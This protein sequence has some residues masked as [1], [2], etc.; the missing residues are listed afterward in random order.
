[1]T[2]GGESGIGVPEPV[3][4]HLRKRFDI[5][6]VLGRGGSAIVLRA[7]HRELDRPVA[8]KL[9]A[10]GSGGDDLVL[11]RAEF[12]GRSQSSLSHPNLVEVYETERLGEHFL[13]VSELVEGGTLLAWMQE[14]HPLPFKAVIERML[15]ITRGLEAIHAAG[16][17]HRDLKAVNI[18]LDHDRRAR[19]TDF[20]LASG[21][22]RRRK[23]LAGMILGTFEYMAPEQVQGQ[24]GDHRADLY[25]LGVLGYELAAGVLPFSGSNPQE[26]LQKIMKDPPRPLAQV[27]GDTPTWYSQ[28]IEGQL[29]AKKPEDRP[30]N[31]TEVLRLLER[32]GSGEV[33]KITQPIPASMGS[34]PR[35]VLTQQVS[36]KVKMAP[37]SSP[38]LTTVRPVPPLPARRGPARLL[39]LVIFVTGALF[40][41]LRDRGAVVLS[42]VRLELH[43][44][45]GSLE[46]D[47]DSPD[48]IVLSLEDPAG[49]ALQPPVSAPAGE[50]LRIP[51]ALPHSG[52]A[53]HLRL[54]TGDTA[55]VDLPIPRLP[56]F[57]TLHSF[58]D[59]VIFS[60]KEGLD[61][62]KARFQGL[63]ED[64]EREVP[65]R[66]PDDRIVFKTESF[67]DDWR[68]VRLVRLEGQGLLPAP[69]G[70]TSSPVP[71]E[72]LLEPDAATY[73]MRGLG[74]LLLERLKAAHAER[75]AGPLTWEQAGPIIFPCGV[76]GSLEDAAGRF[77][78]LFDSSGLI[79]A[80]KLEN[81]NWL[82]E[83]HRVALG[84]MHQEILAPIPL[85]D[86][87]RGLVHIRAHP[88]PPDFEVP[89]SRL[90]GFL[91]PELASHRRSAPDRREEESLVRLDNIMGTEMIVLSPFFNEKDGIL[92]PKEGC[93]PPL[94]QFKQVDLWAASHSL[95]TPGE[96]WPPPGDWL[97]FQGVVLNMRRNYLLTLRIEGPG[98]EG[99][100]V[101]IFNADDSY[102]VAEHGPDFDRRYS[103]RSWKN[104]AATARTYTVGIRAIALP[105]SGPVRIRLDYDPNP[106]AETT[107]G[108][109]AA[110][111]GYRWDTE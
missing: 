87:Y 64:Q 32:S 38:A 23:T 14:G 99:I 61:G 102:N 69:V 98:R 55:L 77:D 25:S 72:V 58:Q 57:A 111:L 46:V 74:T 9:I 63:R 39:G 18:L 10:L 4:R 97:T 15:E 71:C 83:M 104:F 35:L 94:R 100:A 34:T 88:L 54:S 73:T 43:Q 40:L 103:D 30:A 42:R 45:Q 2:S 13:L 28:L 44:Q 12:E 107:K 19:I 51:F 79:P 81:F 47:V 84:A 31:V 101:S 8:L 91:P 56:R 24:S 66:R 82:V 105:R 92:S 52:E 11:E 70:S 29:L 3:L 22:G 80:D 86:L 75:A 16:V 41:F 78:K 90:H 17:V 36:S 53:I 7:L 49:K 65:G 62:W 110:L 5:Q 59:L 96:S 27:R 108:A 109:T 37:V 76:P 20:G 33:H 60:V 89:L 21:P 93:P 85:E 68:T 67:P 6:G 95:D 48:P 106:H 50:K 26:L 1:M